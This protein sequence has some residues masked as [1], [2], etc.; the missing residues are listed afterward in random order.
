MNEVSDP[1]ETT[2]NAVSEPAETTMNVNIET[3]GERWC[4]FC[5]PYLG[6]RL[7]GMMVRICSGG[8]GVGEA[9]CR[10]G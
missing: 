6:R 7:Q 8:R 1:A 4:H 10:R 9:P 3:V 2:M 5:K